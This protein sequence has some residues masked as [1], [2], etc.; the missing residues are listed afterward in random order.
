MSDVREVS[1]SD[2]STPDINPEGISPRGIA[3]I[4]GVGE[5]PLPDSSPTSADTLENTDRPINAKYANDVY[6]FEGKAPELHARYPEGVRFDAEGYPDFSPYAAET[7]GIDMKGDYTTDPKA[8][9]AEAGFEVGERPEGYLWHHHQDC[10]TMQLVPADLHREV[11]HT[12]GVSVIKNRE[13]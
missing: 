3:A 11:R 9:D 7:F 4:Q 5:Q 8:A 6:S 1:T 13:E 10:R 2:A 12:G